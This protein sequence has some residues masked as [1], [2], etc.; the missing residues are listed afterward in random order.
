[1]RVTDESDFE[2]AVWR[3]GSST[4]IYFNDVW[5]RNPLDRKSVV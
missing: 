4:P 3:N 1:M 2:D 5:S